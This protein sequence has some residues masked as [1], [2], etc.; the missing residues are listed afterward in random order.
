M[1]SE[2]HLSVAQHVFEKDIDGG[3]LCRS[4]FKERSRMT[5]IISDA[6]YTYSLVAVVKGN[7]S[8]ALSFARQHIKLNYRAWAMLEHRVGKLGPS[9][10]SII[11]NNDSDFLVDQVSRLS[12]EGQSSSTNSAAHALLRS[13]PFWSLVPRLFRGLVHISQLFAHHGLLQEAQYYLEQGQEIAHKVKSVGLQSQSLALRGDIL[14]CNGNL[15]QGMVMLHQALKL[16][17]SLTEDHHLV[18][19]QLFIANNHTLQNERVSAAGAFESAETLIESLTMMP[20]VGESGLQP[21]TAKS[22]VVKVDELKIVEPPAPRK[23]RNPRKHIAK[24]PRDKSALAVRS[25]SPKRRTSDAIGNSL[26]WQ[27]KGKA[28]RQRAIVATYDN[29]IN[30]ATSCLQEA[31]K[32]TNLPH[33]EMQNMFVKGLLYLRQALERMAADP[34]FC[35]LLEST[36]SQPSVVKRHDRLDTVVPMHSFATG[37]ECSPPK[38]ITIKGSLKKA[39]H[40]LTP[41][42]LEFFDLLQQAQNTI[43][44]IHHLA[45]S[46]GSTKN[47]HTIA[48][49][50]T[51]S[52]TMLSANTVS[53]SGGIPDPSFALYVIGRYSMHG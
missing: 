18:S 33:E 28:L 44:N 17:S 50:L 9:G 35:I 23:A 6:S 5:Q 7:F 27:I 45:I 43:V 32:T 51:K 2:E 13:A 21:I 11:S 47:V 22:P 40:A 39:I 12:L 31:V 3:N 49:V 53:S 48:D 10:N 46:M 38:K 41:S 34:A 26:L 1:N 15:K 20:I 24:I 16:R 42:Q 25:F 14:T 30:I 36:I 8:K 4:K 29:R 52:L 19:L 37:A